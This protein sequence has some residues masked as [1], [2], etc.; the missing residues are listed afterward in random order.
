MR[1]YAI[2]FPE[3]F[4]HLIADGLWDDDLLRAVSE[5]FPDPSIPEWRRFEN[6]S[7]RKLE[8]APGLWGKATR[9]LF[10]QIKAATPQLE[11]AFGIA[12]LRM[13]T[14][15]GGYHLIPPGGYL[16]VHA[17]FNRSPQTGWF[18]RLNH[19]IYLNDSWDDPGGHL[20]LWDD[21]GR[22][23]DVSPEFNRTVVFETSDHS[24]HGHPTPAVRW[25]KS[26][27]AYFFT[28]QAPPGYTTEH[29]TLWHAE[30]RRAP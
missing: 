1:D 12:G 11:D 29:S 6:S 5:E 21:E 20:E 7:E 23:A 18:R 3:P 14:V 22:V 16:A 27:A 17:D 28:E 13:E 26:I 25:R 30:A 2:P 10:E 4:P 15:G 24:W 8:G 9:D 19:L